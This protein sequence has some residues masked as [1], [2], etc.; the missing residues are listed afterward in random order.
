M[1]VVYHYD[2]NFSCGIWQTTKKLIGMQSANK[3]RTY[4]YSTYRSTHGGLKGSGREYS[5]TFENLKNR[6]NDIK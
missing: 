5:D 3:A 6:P 2:F 4:H 1:T